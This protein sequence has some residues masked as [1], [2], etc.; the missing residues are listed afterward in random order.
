[1]AHLSAN[2]IAQTAELI[3]ATD[4]G[5]AATDPFKLPLMFRSLLEDRLQ[6]Y[7]MVSQ[8]LQ[9]ASGQRSGH[10]GRVKESLPRLRQRLRDGFKFLDALPDFRVSES[11][12]QSALLAYG[13]AG[14]KVGNLEPKDRV[15]E[16]ARLA[17]SMTPSVQPPEARYP[18]DLLAQ[19]ESELSILSE[20][21]PGSRI[22]NRSAAT[23]ARDRAL[24]ELHR[25]VTRLRH[26]YIACSDDIDETPELA[27]IGM[28]PTHRSGQRKVA[29]ESAVKPPIGPLPPVHTTP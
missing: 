21:E 17:L 22:G 13:W 10:S 29:S 27:K 3:L 20:A 18:A 11:A 9:A 5:R 25:A 12:K 7:R 14:L 15:F 28:N 16:L 6:H 4:D 19:I 1:M 2:Q 23:Q 24:K 8:N 26:Y